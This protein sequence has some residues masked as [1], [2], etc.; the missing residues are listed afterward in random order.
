MQV[1]YKKEEIVEI[2]ELANLLDDFIDRLNNNT[3]EKVAISDN[4]QIEAVMIS[5][6]EYEKVLK[7]C[8]NYSSLK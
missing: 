4:N 3:L 8:N 7:L 5:V 2:D 1:E 6:D